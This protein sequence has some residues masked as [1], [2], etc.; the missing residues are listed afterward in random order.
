[1]LIESNV[2][3]SSFAHQY[4]DWKG[5][6]LLGLREHI[7][8]DSDSVREQPEEAARR[9]HDAIKEATELISRVITNKYRPY[10]YKY[11]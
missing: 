1:M 7:F 10:Q 8:E 11:Q 3:Y 2:F 5:V 9:L 4:K 6:K